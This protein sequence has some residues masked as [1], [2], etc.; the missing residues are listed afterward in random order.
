MYCPQC[1]TQ[2][3]DGSKFCFSCGTNLETGKAPS[4]PQT[5]PQQSQPLPTAITYPVHQEMHQTQTDDSTNNHNQ[6]DQPVV[7]V[8]FGEAISLY[9]QK[10]ATFEGRAT[11]SEYW[12]AALFNGLVGFGLGIISLLAPILSFLSIAYSLAVLV[13]GFAISWRRLHDIGKSGTY[14]LMALIPLAGPI[15]LTIYLCTDSTE[16]NQYGPRKTDRSLL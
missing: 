12:F 8:G 10:Y 7:A 3:K 15:I 14:Y 2:V 4:K 1:G 6:P 16:D 13:P 5:Q 9:F 11:R